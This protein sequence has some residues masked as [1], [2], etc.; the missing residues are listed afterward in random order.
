MQHRWQSLVD[1]EAWMAACQWTSDGSWVYGTHEASEETN[2][3]QN[4]R[5]RWQSLVPELLLRV[6]SQRE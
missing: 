1:H 3:V 5:L 2:V 4:S 6:R